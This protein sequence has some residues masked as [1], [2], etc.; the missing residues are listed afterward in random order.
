MLTGS[1]GQHHRAEGIVPVL[2]AQSVVERRENSPEGLGRAN[3]D[4]IF[5]ERT[6]G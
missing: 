6:L 2:V 5:L 1:Q 3:I 4:L